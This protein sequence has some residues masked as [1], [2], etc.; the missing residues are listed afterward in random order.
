MGL[1]ITNASRKIL[2]GYSP[3]S[4]ERYLINPPRDVAASGDKEKEDR[5]RKSGDLAIVVKNLSEWSAQC[6]AV[7]ISGR[8]EAPRGNFLASLY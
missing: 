3:F 4:A 1:K 8:P 2:T 7:W 5:G 6:L